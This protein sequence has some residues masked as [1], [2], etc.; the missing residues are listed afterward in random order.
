MGRF[1]PQHEKALSALQHGIDS[2][3]LYDI[4]K[5]R[6]SVFQEIMQ[7]IP[8]VKKC[9]INTSYHVNIR[10]FKHVA[11]LALPTPTYI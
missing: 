7:F 10:Y 3:I 6:C 11:K 1:F 8:I 2:I 9:R 4:C 5:N